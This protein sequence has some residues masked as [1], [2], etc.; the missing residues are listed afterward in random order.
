MVETAAEG[1]WIF[2]DLLRTIFV[3]SRMA[4]MVGCTPEDMQ[5][6]PVSDFMANE[7]IAAQL[8]HFRGNVI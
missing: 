4:E 1:V 5:G 6:K 7:D 8:S 2:D 3:N